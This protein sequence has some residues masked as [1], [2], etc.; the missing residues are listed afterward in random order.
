M[1][2]GFTNQVGASIDILLLIKY[3]SSI[4]AG[5]VVVISFPKWETSADGATSPKSCLSASIACENNSTSAS[6][7]CSYTTGTSFNS[8]VLTV[9]DLITAS[10]SSGSNDTI[11]IKNFINYSQFQTYLVDVSVNTAS[12]TATNTLTGIA[13][14]PTT[15]NTASQ[16]LLAVTNVTVGAETSYFISVKLTTVL[17]ISSYL[18]VT[19]PSTVYHLNAANADI[20]STVGKASMLNSPTIDKTGLSS[21]PYYF[22]LTGMV[23]GA[24]NYRSRDQTF[25]IQINNLMNPSSIA[26]TGS[27]T[28]GLYDSGDNRYE[29]MDTGITMTATA[30]ALVE[31]ISPTFSA[32]V[33]TVL[34]STDF[35]L[36]LATQTAIATGASASIVVTFPSEFT[37]TAGTC[38]LSNLVGFS[39][40][41]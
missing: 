18:R 6:L 17:P 30:G 35:T 9:T 10:R 8:D 26:T 32:S 13:M 28:I 4:D 40:S 31:V 27:F 11:R 3:S 41:T 23:T 15:E 16:I 5:S 20:I 1:A 22:D 36:S 14:T 21:S 12:G 2:A 24:S 25:Y 33:L 34:D 39:S 19:L 38:T 7:T 37:L 29:Y